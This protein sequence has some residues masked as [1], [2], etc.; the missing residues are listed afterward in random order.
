[1]KS[2]GLPSRLRKSDVLVVTLWTLLLL[3]L[4][5][6]CRYMPLRTSQVPHLALSLS[7][8]SLIPTSNIMATSASSEEEVFDFIFK[9]RS[10]CKHSLAGDLTPPRSASTL[11]SFQT[12]SSAF[13]YSRSTE[14]GITD[15]TSPGTLTTPLPPLRGGQITYKQAIAFVEMLNRADEDAAQEVARIKDCIQEV[16][17]L[18]A[19]CKV[20]KLR[21]RENGAENKAFVDLGD[22]WLDF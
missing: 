18:V 6:V 3:E 7:S 22:S 9:S 16:R 10:Y 13:S 8:S 20:E 12:T 4:S 15:T 21:R 1:M 17:N 2:I 14:M 19:E 5:E 11:S